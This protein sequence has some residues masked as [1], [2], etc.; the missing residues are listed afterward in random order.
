MLKRILLV[1][2]L[3][4][5]LP[6][7]LEGGLRVALRL[8]GTPYDAEAVRAEIETVRQTVLKAIPGLE[9]TVADPEGGKIPH[10]YLGWDDLNRL[11]QVR[12]ESEKFRTGAFDRGFEILIVGGSVSGLVA[13]NGGPTI[14]DTLA[15]DP[16][17]G[18]RKITILSHG[19][20][21][22][23]QPQQVML[24]A[25][26]LGL[27]YRPDLILNIDGF[28]E[29]ALGSDNVAL[30]AH[31]LYPHWIQY[32][33][34]VSRRAQSPEVTERL[35]VLRAL[36]ARLAGAVDQGLEHGFL[37]S[38]ILG[39]WTEARVVKLGN[40]CS[41][42]HDEVTEA[43]ASQSTF[44]PTLGPRFDGKHDNTLE[45]VVGGWV[46]ASLQ[47]HAMAKNHGIPYLHVLQPTL[48]DK[49]AKQLTPEEIKH[50]RLKPSWSQGVVDGYPLLRAAAPQ[51]TEQG[52][53]FLDGSD[54]FKEL[55]DETYFDGCHFRGPGMVLFAERVAKEI[56]RGL[57]E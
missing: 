24:V 3:V 35:T 13:K 11:E 42:V 41:A 46:E 15:A 56:L 28:N 27:G 16:R 14:R 7:V 36:Q 12:M 40:Q 23:K 49:G 26:L 43:L 48:H 38:A 52:V 5:A 37:R 34:A 50:G 17:F 10:P 25:Y 29:V 30:G 2:A 4:I 39:R 54:T 31:P 20:G 44:D 6:F 19:R 18:D 53:W 51:L 1:L 33:P 47:I 45:M 22:F 9:D 21:S 55:A 32:A 8:R 57:P